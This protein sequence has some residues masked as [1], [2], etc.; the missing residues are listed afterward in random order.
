MRLLA[1]IITLVCSVAPAMATAEIEED[2]PIVY[3]QPHGPIQT[4]I[5][6]RYDK[7]RRAVKRSAIVS[8]VSDVATNVIMLCL[9]RR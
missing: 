3:L 9:R 4:M 2:E 5:L 7:P 6:W 1:I 8:V